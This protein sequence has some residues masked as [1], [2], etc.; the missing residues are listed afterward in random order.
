MK[1]NS[2]EIMEIETAIDLLTNEVL[3]IIQ[4]RALE[5]GLNPSRV[6]AAVWM[7]MTE[8]VLADGGTREAMVKAVMQAEPNL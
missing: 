8:V 6:S 1:K 5:A 7:L 4:S 2:T 3:E